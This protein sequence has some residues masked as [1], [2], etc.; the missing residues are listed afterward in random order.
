MALSK[1]TF[2]TL[3]VAHVIHIRSA[4]VELTLPDDAFLVAVLSATASA[5]TVTPCS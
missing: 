5:A 4:I 1:V 3:L 2:N